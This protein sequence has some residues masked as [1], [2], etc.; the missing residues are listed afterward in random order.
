[1]FSLGDGAMLMPKHQKIEFPIQLFL[2]MESEKIAVTSWDI[3]LE[4]CRR[5]LTDYVPTPG[6]LNCMFDT[7]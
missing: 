2:F 6:S 1:M 5:E 7:M 4:L 3:S